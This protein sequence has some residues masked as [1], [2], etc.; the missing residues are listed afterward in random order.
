MNHSEQVHSDLLQRRGQLEF[1]KIDRCRWHQNGVLDPVAGCWQVQV[2]A[3]NPSGWQG[4]VGWSYWQVGFLQRD[5]L[6]S[7][8]AG[9]PAWACD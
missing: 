8:P 1:L 7:P 5:S 2:Q 6:R 4:L 9:Q 3:R